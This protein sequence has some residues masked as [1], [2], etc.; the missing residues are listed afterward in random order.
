MKNGQLHYK[1]NAL[2]SFSDGN[3]EILKESNSKAGCFLEFSKPQDF[4]FATWS[5]IRIKGINRFTV[6]YRKKSYW[7][8]PHFGVKESQ[9]PK[10]CTIIWVQRIDNLIMVLVPLIDKG[11]NS[12]INGTE[13]GIEIISDNKCL[14]GNSRKIVGLYAGVGKDFY[15]VTER[16]ARE[17]S[18][19]IGVGL[20]RKD[21][22]LPPWLDFLGYCTWNTFYKK[23]NQENVYRMLHY[24]VI[25]NRINLGYLLLDDGWQVI[26]FF[27][28][29]DK[30][31]DLNK[32]PEGLKK[33]FERIKENFHIQD[34]LVWHTFQ[35]YWGGIYLKGP[36][37]KRFK[38]VSM[39]FHRTPS[40]P[41][42]LDL[43]AKSLEKIGSDW[44]PISKHIKIPIGICLPDQM[45]KL[46]DDY[47]G[48]LA[49]Q[50]VTGVKVDNQTAMEMLAFN[51][52][53]QANVMRD[54]HKV[55][56]DSVS[57][58]F[59]KY[60]LMNCMS[61][62]TNVFYQ[63]IGS[64]I[65]RNSDDY[66]PKNE[67]SQTEHVI[68]NAYNN[69]WSGHFSLPDWDMFQS[70]HP[71]G[72]FQA[73]SRAISGSPVYFADNFK[74]VNKE[75]ISKVALPN[76]RI[77][78]CEEPSLICREMIFR[79]PAKPNRALKMFNHNEFNSVLGIFNVMLNRETTIQYS[80]SDVEGLNQKT[81]YAVYSTRDGTLREMDYDEKSPLKL[82]VKGFDVLTISIIN[83]G[84]APIGL[85]NKYNPGGI[86]EQMGMINGKLIVHVKYGGLI[87]FYC[88]RKPKKILSEGLKLQFEYSTESKLLILSVPEKELQIFEIDDN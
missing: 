56:E 45:A 40:Y 78:R 64:N 52:G 44:Y 46:W 54:Y 84:F 79:N 7:Y 82:E 58:H 83:D 71:W 38:P 6:L 11:Y 5:G 55:L 25:Q 2:L 72:A 13:N 15:K 42:P 24:L 23:I 63:L 1:E 68:V 50:G 47:H 12:Y 21:K 33:L 9:I 81:R 60:S 86:F 76:G 74:N 3:I 80:P 70:D 26:K 17:I 20:L 75:I 51:L 59:S 36:Y 29:Y 32:F 62:N 35:G 88:H 66:F 4:S 18:E 57:K 69:L 53:Y 16:A 41:K 39:Q 43:V 14:N 8:W 67:S 22:G 77:L 73:A 30:G 31:A 27:G 87:G 49:S 19:F 28:L 48:W 10:F 37:G 65:T 34:I 61:M 85:L